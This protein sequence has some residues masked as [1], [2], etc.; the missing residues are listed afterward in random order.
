MTPKLVALLR[1]VIQPFRSGAGGSGLLGRAGSKVLF[2]NI[3]SVHSLFLV[4][5]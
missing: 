3:F 2:L 5:R 4:L 1:E